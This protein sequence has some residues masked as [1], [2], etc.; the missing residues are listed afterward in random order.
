M[1]IFYS[2]YI[3]ILNIGISISSLFNP[4]AK[5]WRSGRNQWREK[6]RLQIPD[7]SDKKVAWFHVSSLGEYEQAI[8]LM[9]KMRDKKYLV[10]V[11]FFSPSG[12]DHADNTL[13]DIKFYLPLDTINNAEAL[14]EILKPDIVFWIKNDFWIHTLEAISK[15][16][17]PLMMVSLIFN[18]DS[19][20]L[21]SGFSLLQNSLASANELFV[22]NKQSK[23]LLEK[24]EITNVTIAGDTRITRVKNRKLN[25]TPNALL[26][27]YSKSSDVIYYASVHPSDMHVV[28]KSIE[29]YQGYKHIIIPHEIDNQSVSSLLKNISQPYIYINDLQHDSS[30]NIL[31]INKMGILFDLY[32]YADIVYIGGGYGRGIHNIL[33]P[34]VFGKPVIFGPHFKKFDEACNFVNLDLCYTIDNYLN[35]QK[36]LGSLTPYKRKSI[37]QNLMNYYENIED[38]S[39]IIM[40]YCVDKK[41]IT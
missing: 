30:E 34:T 1:K 3:F 19:F 15:N 12:Y 36:I 21:N 6:L 9:Q 23:C 39:K 32:K 38:A 41:L 14:L 11:S 4:K 2:L 10:A 17:I 13:I 26:D 28:N 20:F 35:F 24:K 5:K 25:S 33:E 22:Q 40:D 27:H 31:V 16:G 18:K 29:E 7:A 37:H 8:P